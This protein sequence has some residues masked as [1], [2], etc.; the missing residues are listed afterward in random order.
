MKMLFYGTTDFMEF[1]GTFKDEKGAFSGIKEFL[2]R[3]NITAYYYRMWPV[4]YDDGEYTKVDYGSHT[5]FFF[6][7]ELD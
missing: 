6:I 1:V 7:R 3:K 5:R 2:N 4:N